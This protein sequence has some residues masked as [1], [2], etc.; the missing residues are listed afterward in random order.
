[1]NP[2]TIRG[3]YLVHKWTSLICTIFLLLLCVTGLPLIFYHEIDHLVGNSVDPPEMPGVTARA[4]LDDIVEA[5]KARRP[6]EAVKFLVSDEDEP[7]AW[8][9]R[10]GE[11]A[12]SQE[13][14][15]LSMF[16]ARTG[17]FIHDYPVNQGIMRILW[18]LH[19]DMF[20]GL[21]GTLFLGAMG[22]LFL[23]AIISGIVLYAPFMRKLSFGSIRW[24][25]SRRTRWLDLHNLLG[26]VTVVWALV[27][28]ATGSINTLA[29]PIF[30]Q[31]QATE[32]ASMLAPYQGQVSSVEPG[33]VDRV[34]KAARAAEP[35]GELFFL[36]FPGTRF[37]GPQHYTAF[38]RGKT[39]LTSKLLKP[40]LIQATTAQ[41]ADSRELPW[42][43]TV[44]LLSQ[45]LHFGDYGGLP[46][47]L[48]WAF[49]DIITIIVLGS[50][51]YLWKKKSAVS[52]EDQA[53][54]AVE[55]ED[56]F[57]LSPSS[58]KSSA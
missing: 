47:K 36:A 41:V 31:W 44:L 22:L 48:I 51:L 43:V 46:L 35:D 16:D 19:V 30:Q 18:R 57:V 58:R 10:F 12:T 23:A 13:T 54:A 17:K 37:A 9:V 39:P 1:M 50:G 53:L 21:P 52:I 4:N 15:T 42:Y 24:E 34:V 27:V 40:V 11:T 25:R 56:A 28:G 38:M 26:I 5:A 7:Y 55:Q 14:S 33:S 29:N 8:W 45:P 32:L 20:T 2:Q 6:N 49:L 3:W